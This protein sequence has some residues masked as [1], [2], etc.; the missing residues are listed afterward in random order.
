MS[1]LCAQQALIKAIL[2]ATVA[3]I[4]LQGRVNT[5]RT[6]L[7]GLIFVAGMFNL[8]L[9]LSY[10]FDPAGAAAGHGVSY[11]GQLGLATLRADF[12]AFFVVIGLCMLRGAW[13]RNGDVLLVPAALFGIALFGRLLTLMLSGSGPGFYLPMAAEAGQVILLVLGWRWVPHHK[14]AE[15]TG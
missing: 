3:K 5:V 12:T 8:L 14:V 9:G 6:I 15:L 1:F 11:T 7:I 4:A 13:K 10:L 2:W